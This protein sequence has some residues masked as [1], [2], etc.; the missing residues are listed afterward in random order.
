LQGVLLWLP[1]NCGSNKRITLESK[2]RD[3]AHVRLCMPFVHLSY[4]MLSCDMHVLV[5]IIAL[6]SKYDNCHGQLRGS[7]VLKPKTSYVNM[8][9]VSVRHELIQVEGEKKKQKTLLIYLNIH[10]EPMI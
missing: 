7:I 10:I 8:R 4:G 3:H 9:S 1:S 5:S 6:L 2:A